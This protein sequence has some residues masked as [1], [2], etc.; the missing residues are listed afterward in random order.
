MR[1]DDDKRQAERPLAGP[2]RDRRA[3]HGW[4]LR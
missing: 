2:G 3:M 1:R 4:L